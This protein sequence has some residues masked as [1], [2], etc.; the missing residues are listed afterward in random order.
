MRRLTL[1]ALLV[2]LPVAIAAGIA[3]TTGGMAAST[4][5]AGTATAV[6]QPIAGPVGARPAPTADDSA[7]IRGLTVHEWGTFTSVAGPDGTAI[8]WQ[9]AGGPTDLPCFV[10]VSGAGPKGLAIAEQGGRSKLAKVRMETPVLYFYSK[11]EETVSVKVSFPHGLMTEWYPSD[12]K[13]T[14]NVYD[15]Q[16]AFPDVSGTIQWN[17]VKVMPGAT[18]SYP[19]EDSPSHYYAARR[20][21]SAPVQVGTQFEKFLFYRGIANFDPPI[22][23]RTTKDGKIE[24]ANLGSD[25]IP[26]V[27]LFENRGGRIGYGIAQGLSHSV[28]MDRPELNANFASLQEDLEGM[29]RSQGMFAQEA[30]AMVDTWKDSWFEQ[31]TRV[32]YIVPSHTV[33]STLPLEVAPKPVAVARAFV[34]R[35]EVL[36]PATQM[37]VLTAIQKRDTPVLET[38]GRFLEPIVNTFYAKLSDTEWKAA[39]DSIA[40]IRSDYVANAKACT[41]KRNW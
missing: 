31:G 8:S 39:S 2:A 30:R 35:M 15:A 38:Y 26:A 4:S 17:N 24:V 12:V 37:E 10:T 14:P 32:F 23:A 27:V 1:I 41:Q 18:A 5:P 9:P 22:S 34:G 6:W 13:L 36:T 16:K 28:Q 40:S 3:G 21:A 33:D 25:S 7:A 19:Y 20:T 29:L 11:E